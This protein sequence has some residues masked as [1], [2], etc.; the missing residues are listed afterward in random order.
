ME[1]S[2][3]T[4]KKLIDAIN[5][6]SSMIEELGEEYGPID[7]LERVRMQFTDYMDQY[8]IHTFQEHTKALKDFQPS[9]PR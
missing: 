6:H 5:R 3:E 1:L 8:V 4:A 9:E 7:R 2:E